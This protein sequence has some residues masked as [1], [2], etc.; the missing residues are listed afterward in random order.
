MNID[1]ESQSAPAPAPESTPVPAPA[2]DET[3]APPNDWRYWMRRLLVCNPFFLCS[4]ALLLY[5]V[6]RLSSVDSLF[7]GEIHNLF[8]NFSALQFYETLVVFAGILLARRKIWYDSSLLVVVEQGL[9]LVPFLLI[10]QATVQHQEIRDGM[11]LAGTLALAGVAATAGRMLSIR[12]F[13]P[14]FN[15]PPRALLL[16][17]FLLVGNVVLPLVFRV[18]IEKDLLDWE[19][20]NQ[21]LWYFVLPLLVCGANLLPKPGRYGGSNPE[22][23]WLPIFI[24]G[25]WSA[26]SAAH[27][28]SM[29]HICGFKMELHQL[30]PVACA[31]VWTLWHRLHDFL[32]TPSPRMRL[33]VLVL[34]LVAPLLAFGNSTVFTIL[35]TGTHLGYTVL[36]LRS[37]GTWPL[38]SAVGH[39]AMVSLAMILAGLPIEWARAALPRID[40]P[41]CVVIAGAILALLHA[42]RS[43]TPFAGIVA[44]ATTALALTM[45]SASYPS[46][47]IHAVVQISVVFLLLHSIRWNSNE[48]L[49]ENLLRVGAGGLWLLDAAIWTSNLQLTSFLFSSIAAAVVLLVSCLCRGRAFRILAFASLAVICCAPG[50][51]LSRNASAGAMA[52]I[53][54]LALFAIGM[55]VAWTRHRWDNRNESTS[56]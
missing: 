14:Q 15:L 54:S 39:L 17:A 1:P 29:A 34:A 27:V 42:L 44:T 8:F 41:G 55:I 35:A 3:P 18:R 21:F 7:A 36:W 26:G 31:L 4:A 6:N 46:I 52:L 38:R 10:S 50:H 28:W 33:A 23:H 2:P 5:A 47:N 40:R 30:A 43:R 19:D 48:P 49:A 51:W 20:E 37:A 12:R 25:L 22:R 13:F 11:N 45:F 56:Q 16:G 24:Y 32:P 53:G 9:V